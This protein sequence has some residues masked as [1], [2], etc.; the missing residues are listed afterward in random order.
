V[1]SAAVEASFGASDGTEVP[2]HAL[3][4]VA[5]SFSIFTIA[6][7]E[8]ALFASESAWRVG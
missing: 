7:L 6:P 5:L 4:S 8:R 1:A 3:K 2:N